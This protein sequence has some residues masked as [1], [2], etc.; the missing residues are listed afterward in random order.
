MPSPPASEAD[1]FGLPRV[2]EQSKATKTTPSPIFISNRIRHQHSPRDPIS[3]IVEESGCSFEAWSVVQKSRFSGQAG[4][5][6]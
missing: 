3:A 2:Y 5:R 1:A 4:W 6:G